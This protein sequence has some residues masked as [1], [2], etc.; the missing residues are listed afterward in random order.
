MQEESQFKLGIRAR[1]IGDFS[2][3]FNK[4]AEVFNNF[5]IK[6]VLVVLFVVFVQESTSFVVFGGDAIV[7]SAVENVRSSPIKNVRSTRAVMNKKKLWKF[8]VIPYE[9]DTTVGFRFKQIAEIEAAMKHWES[10]TCVIFVERIATEHDDYIR[11]T[12]ILECGCCSEVGNIG[13][14]QDVGITNCGGVGGVIHEL[15]HV[16]GFHHEYQRPDRDEYV[17]IKKGIFLEIFDENFFESPFKKLTRD[18]FDT[19]D[20]PYDYDSIMNND[21]HTAISPK[22]GKKGS[23]MKRVQRLSPTDIRKAKKLYKCVE[24]GRTYLDKE[25]AFTSPQYYNKSANRTYQCE[26]RI[27]AIKGE[28]ILLRITDLDTHLI[29][30]TACGLDYLEVYD[31]YWP[32]SPLLARFCGTE[33]PEHI[34]STGHYMFIR[35]VSNNTENKHRGFAANYRTF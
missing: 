12:K 16:I 5:W 21:Q 13:E 15:G 9:I 34:A 26:W 25:G 4:M 6:C 7:Q 18:V 8:G 2:C 24:C 35:Y 10:F 22:R 29:S 14:R 27:K 30:A 23:K 33:I 31:G 1:Y 3:L 17:D 28:R 19:L 32:D 20:E 11:F